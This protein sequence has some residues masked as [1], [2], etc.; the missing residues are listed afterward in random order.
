[1]DG[2]VSRVDSLYHPVKA[3]RSQD[4]YDRFAEVTKA[5]ELLVGNSVNMAAQ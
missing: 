1:M 2:A 3:A 4:R 5:S